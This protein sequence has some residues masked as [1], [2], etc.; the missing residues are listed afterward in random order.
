MANIKR[1]S[2]SLNIRERRIKTTMRHR[3]TPARMAIPKKK[4][5]KIVHVCKDVK[6]REPLYTI[7]T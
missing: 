6:K 2:T 5:Q 7:E 1:C 4:W 3:L